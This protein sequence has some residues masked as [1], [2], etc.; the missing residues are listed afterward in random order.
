MR[1][2]KTELFL[3][4]KFINSVEI[5]S[6]AMI[7]IKSQRQITIREIFAMISLKVSQE[8]FFPLKTD[9]YNHQLPSKGLKEA[10]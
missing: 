4:R 1:N 10:I 5:A 2:L 7:K 3:M 9:L 6:K 8:T